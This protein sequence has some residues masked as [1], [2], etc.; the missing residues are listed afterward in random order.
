MGE[1]V[2]NINWGNSGRERSKTTPT[3]FL[4]GAAASAIAANDSFCK[5]VDSGEIIERFYEKVYEPREPFEFFFGR[6]N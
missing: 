4:A 2:I 6:K 5:Q 1:Y 3:A